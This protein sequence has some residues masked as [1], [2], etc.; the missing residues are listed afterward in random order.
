MKSALKDKKC[1]RK[2]VVA[3]I[4]KLVEGVV[5]GDKE[6][7]AA[8][9]PCRLYRKGK[10]TY[11]FYTILA[12][13]TVLIIDTGFDDDGIK[14]AIKTV[15]SQEFVSYLSG[16]QNEATEEQGAS[17]TDFTS[18]IIESLAGRGKVKIKK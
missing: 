17:K 6:I 5:T 13:N 1:N 8:N 3:A 18:L 16:I 7:F 12:D 2:Q 4:N 11:V 14:R 15:T 10:G 9:L